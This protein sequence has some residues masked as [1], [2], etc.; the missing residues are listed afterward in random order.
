MEGKIGVI[1]NCCHGGFNFSKKAI[2]MYKIINPNFDE[3]CETLRND[4]NMIKIVELLGNEA[5]G[6]YSKLRIEYIDEKYKDYYQIREY[7]GYEWVEI[8]KNKYLVDKI[9]NILKNDDDNDTKISKMNNL[10]NSNK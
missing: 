7:D 1:I 8:K 3:E 2:D 4:D 10:F 9:K 5:N 6:M